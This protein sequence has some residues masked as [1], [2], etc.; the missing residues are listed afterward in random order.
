MVS[1]KYHSDHTFALY[2]GVLIDFDSTALECAL[3][4][5]LKK[6]NTR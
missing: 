5:K 1:Y 4:A 6:I 2:S 3:L